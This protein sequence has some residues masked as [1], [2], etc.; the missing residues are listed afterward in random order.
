MLFR[1]IF[2]GKGIYSFTGVAAD[3]V[4]FKH[5]AGHAIGSIEF[6][7]QLLLK[8]PLP[9]LHNFPYLTA[10][11]AVSLRIVLSRS[12]KDATL[13]GSPGI[14]AVSASIIPPVNCIFK[15]CRVRS[16]PLY[17]TASVA[18]NRPT[19]IR[20]QTFVRLRRL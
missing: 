13:S 12:V 7:S 10:I 14:Q 3:H 8:L 4:N 6:C 9:C 19:F 16:A 17:R 18:Q 2:L 5:V 1:Y 11:L 20:K 15:A